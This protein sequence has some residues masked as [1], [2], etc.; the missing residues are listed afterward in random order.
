MAAI[1]DIMKCSATQLTQSPTHWLLTTGIAVVLIS[2]SSGCDRHRYQPATWRPA[3][4][5]TDTDDSAPIGDP[6]ILP[7]PI[8]PM[9]NWTSPEVLDESGTS[10]E[11]RGPVGKLQ[12][13]AN[14]QRGSQGPA[15][16]GQLQQRG[17]GAPARGSSL[18]RR[19]VGTSRG[20][21]APERG[22]AEPPLS[23]E[24]VPRS[25][26]R[27]TRQRNAGSGSTLSRRGAAT[28]L[29]QLPRLDRQPAL[30]LRATP[31]AFQTR[32]PAVNAP[33]NPL[34]KSQ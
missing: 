19:G 11:W 29:P 8:G 1:I 10:K 12:A 20:S 7:S 13:P 18:P 15:R 26:R 6:D 4:R 3:P 17:S 25:N 31:T 32:K 34:R 28:P 5:V 16:G 14:R 23:A 30:P 27:E 24:P 21:S 2:L 33:V 22:F 9:T